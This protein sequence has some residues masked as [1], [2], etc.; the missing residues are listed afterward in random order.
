MNI[1]HAKVGFFTYA[2]VCVEIDPSL[3]DD[4][5]D[6]LAEDSP[7]TKTEKNIN[8]GSEEEKEDLHMSSGVQKEEMEF[9]LRW[10]I[11]V[12]KL[13]QEELKGLMNLYL[14]ILKRSQL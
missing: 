4:E 7:S 1:D 10:K 11:A 2:Q 14:Q 12:M 8:C 6:K 3:Q 5:D 9:T 13:Q